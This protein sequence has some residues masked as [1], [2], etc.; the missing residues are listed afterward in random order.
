LPPSAPFTVDEPRLVDVFAGRALTSEW[1]NTLSFLFG[2]LVGSFPEP[3]K[4]IDLLETLLGRADGGGGAL[5]LVL[6]ELGQILTGK[7]VALRRESRKKLQR[8]LFDAMLGDGE[9]RD[10]ASLGSALGRLGDDRF[11][12]DFFWLPGDEQLGFIKVKAGPFTMGSRE[13]ER[14]TYKDEQPRHTVDLPEF[15]IARY[16]V[17]VAQLGAF[18][19]DADFQ[20]GDRDSL[21]GVPNHP[22]VLVSWHEAL[23][24]CEWL[25]Q[26]LRSS[27]W[28]PADL[29]ARLEDG[30]VIT[31]PSEAEWEKAARGADGRI[32]PWGDEFDQSK[33]NGLGAG[34]RT[35]SA[36]GLFLE[37]ASPCGA[38]DMSGNVWEWTRSLWEKDVEKPAFTYP[39]HPGDLERERLDAPDGVRRVVRGGSF[40]DTEYA[41]RVAFRLRGS[42]GFRGGYIGFR[43]VSSRLRS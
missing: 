37:G 6:A 8:L 4:A 23:A 17:T 28:A 30:W 9:I 11:S 15:W 36:V 12:P 41:L 19:S 32:Y 14:F 7:G 20:V 10:R 27:P 26:K 3:I 18:F 35:T 24:Y 5:L 21:R 39:Y 2:R 31:L 42:P 25:T 40:Y 22:V 38:L 1:H 34:L 13:D 43:V 29:R 33:A 16:P